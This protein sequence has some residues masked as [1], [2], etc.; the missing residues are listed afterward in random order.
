MWVSAGNG[1]KRGDHISHLSPVCG[2]TLCTLVKVGKIIMAISQWL[3][4]YLLS[5]RK[6]GNVQECSKIQRT[7]NLLKIEA[8]LRSKHQKM[9]NYCQVN[10]IFT[11]N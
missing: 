2:F 7:A 4:R 10:L 6:A 11:T 5:C 1:K 3:A 8:V 9:L